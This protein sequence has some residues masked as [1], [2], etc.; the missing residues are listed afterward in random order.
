MNPRRGGVLRPRLS[1]PP[2]TIATGA[3]VAIVGFFSS[4]PIVLQGI[5]AMGANAAQATSAL[6]VAALS[7]GLTGV[8]LAVWFRSPITVAWSTPGAA[9]LAIS[10]APQGGYSDALGAFVIAG[11]LCVVA[12]LWRP[13][14]RLAAAIPTSLAQAMLAGVLLPIC[15]N[16]ARALPDLPQFVIPIFLAW[17]IAGRINRLAAVPAAVLVTAVLVATLDGV[18]QISETGLFSAPVWTTPSFSL[19]SGISIAIPLFI[20][21]MATQNIPGIAIM[22]SHGFSPPAGPLFATVGIASI[23]TAPFGAFSTCLAAITSAMCANEDSHPDPA[24]RYWSAVVA[25]TGY[26]VLGLFAGLVTAFAALA[27]PMVVASLAG[28]ALMSVLAGSA[29]AALADPKDREAAIV[30]LLITASGITFYD[31]GAPVWGL[32]IGG[33]VYLIQ[34]WARGS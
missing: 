7:M 14:G 9:L 23:L 11:A 6:M 4:F 17:L 5:S 1:P 25:G 31:L 10:A 20:V 12:G 33:M 16:P 13:I 26:C 32:L 34:R 3:V 18:P 30:T 27:P 2:Q 8:V 15:L 24:L 21:S 28:L 19:A 29:Q 22:R